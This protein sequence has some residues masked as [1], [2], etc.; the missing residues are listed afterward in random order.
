LN[1][2]LFSLRFAIEQR[3]TRQVVRVTSAQPMNEPFVD[4]LLELGG[5]NNR[6]LREY[7]F[8][9][10]PADLRKSQPVQ[11]AAP[12]TPNNTLSNNRT[13][14]SR[15]AQS[16]AQTEAVAQS[17][18][19]EKSAAPAKQPAQQ[20]S[21]QKPVAPEATK[22]ATAREGA[23]EGDQYRTKQGD[24]L[25]KIAG[26]YRQ[27]GISLDQMLVAMHKANPNAFVGNNI[28]RLKSGQI[29]SIPSA[30]AAGSVSQSEARK[31][32]VAQAADFNSYRVKL[33]EQAGN[34]AAQKSEDVK[35]SATG[36]I[37]SQVEEPSIPANESKD[38]LKLSKSGTAASGADK[39]TGLPAGTED[40]IA[41][42]K[43]IAEANA[44]VKELEKNVTDL[45]KLLEVQNK[46]LANTQKQAEA[47]K[48]DAAPA[49]PASPSDAAAPAAAT[50]AAPVTPASEQP[51]AG[52]EAQTP[53]A[54]AP[55]AA[56]LEAEAPKTEAPPLAPP[57]PVAKKPVAPP[58]PPAP[59]PSFI[60]VLLEDPMLL[61][62]GAGMIALLGG[63]A[64]FMSRR[65]KQRTDFEDSNVLDESSLK[66]NSL[67]ASTG[68][69]SVDTNNSVFNSSFAPSASQLDTNEVDPVAEADVY[70]AY[71]RDAQ[72]EEILKEALRT[73]PER[74]AVRVKLL[75]IYAHRK[76]ARSFENVASELYSLTKGKGEDWTQAV[77][78][79]VVIDPKNPLYAGG[80]AS[81]SAVGG[82]GKLDPTTEQLDEL[83]L[84][85]LL[86]TTRGAETTI[87]P[88]EDDA[89]DPGTS[90]V[91][92]P[93]DAVQ[94]NDPVEEAAADEN[95]IEFV[96]EPVA[97]AQPNA[98]KEEPAEEA[99]EPETPSALD[100]D[101]DLSGFGTGK[102]THASSSETKAELSD[103]P[104][105]AKG[106]DFDFQLDKPVMVN[107]DEAELA[108]GL[109]MADSDM[110]N[111]G[112]LDI[113]I[114][115]LSESDAKFAAPATPADFD[116]SGISLD[117]NAPEVDTAVIPNENETGDV[118]SSNAAE[119][120]TKLDL[121]LAYQE[122]GDKDGARELLDEVIKGGTDDQI[123]KAKAM[124]QKLA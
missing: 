124:L 40:K 99:A 114:P 119:M 70:I 7:T 85:A 122:I 115:D 23:S 104:D 107:A 45:Q 67:F 66:A 20:V 69:Q 96:S 111:F 36:K 2:A 123:Q 64:V 37:T 55:P 63:A 24:T 77:N 43:A 8:L 62:L 94:K 80:N 58:P 31:I 16:Q 39:A 84:A 117:L 105:F 53:G 73:Q 120:A 28:N 18:P 74:N 41:K 19:V 108:A 10:D 22:T 86:N 48:N 112:S 12:V 33:A 78:M 109:D 103:E 25:A 95:L 100:F 82:Q 92:T 60:D 79:G 1:P 89:L 61:G 57:A 54:V 52:T 102:E 4:M 83:D 34:A 91:L 101:F 121:A 9:L 14:P 68:G 81:E 98:G 75:E 90:Y 50:T 11:L 30:E 46:D 26:Q 44:R 65:R 110:D 49:K 32:V 56:A 42:D 116:L 5:T 71:G 15:S 38:K 87:A 76:D 51:A 35:Q 21:A 6:L 17:A 97:E 13:A 113:N 106:M 47:P 72:A 27:E 93:D 59:E 88:E 29:L 3:G 118:A